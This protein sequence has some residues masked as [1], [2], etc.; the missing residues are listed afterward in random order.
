MALQG[1][2]Q[3]ASEAARKVKVG[4]LGSAADLPFNLRV[5]AKAGII[6]PLPPSKIVGVAGAL[7]RWGASPAAGAASC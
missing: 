2:A 1:I 6:R 3:K 7:R 5:L 4:Q